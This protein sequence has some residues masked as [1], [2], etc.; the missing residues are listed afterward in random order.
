LSESLFKAHIDKL[1]VEKS[2]DIAFFPVDPRLKESYYI[3]GEY[4]AK[5]IQPKLFIPM[6]FGEEISITKDFAKKM[7]DFHIKAVEIDYSGQEI[8]Y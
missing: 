4:F 1:K 7:R 8:I 3:G 5:Q 2:I 6:H